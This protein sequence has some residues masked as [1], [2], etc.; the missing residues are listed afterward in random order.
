M[1]LSVI[2]EAIGWQTKFMKTKLYMKQRL[3]SLLISAIE[4]GDLVA[5]KRVLSLGASLKP[6]PVPWWKRLWCKRNPA[7]LVLAIKNDRNDIVDLLLSA[8]ADPNQLGQDGTSPL[9]RA[10]ADG[11]AEL[12]RRLIDAGADIDLPDETGPPLFHATV[13]GHDNIVRQLLA[14]GADADLVLQEPLRSYAVS[15]SIL[16]MLVEFGGQPDPE[17]MKYIR[18]ITE[19]K[20]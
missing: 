16:K 12:V 13:A 3:Y 9:T 5:V 18:E 4:A 11:K 15:P 14:V 10:A 1:A 20:H 17:T 8:G 6:P 19:S 2:T 7:P